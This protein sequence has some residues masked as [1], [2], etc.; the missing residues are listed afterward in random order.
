MTPTL[1]AQIG[2]LLV[3]SVPVL[4]TLIFVV[5]SALPVGSIGTYSLAPNF[6]LAMCLYWT[7]RRPDLFPPIS[8]F[9]LG[10]TADLL[11]SGALG[12]WSMAF[13]SAYAFLL[14]QRVLFVGRVALPAMVGVAIG[15]AI[16]LGIVWMLTGW[17][18]GVMVP[19][20][21]LVVHGLMT[22]LVFPLCAWA[23]GR[24]EQYLPAPD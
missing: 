10:L 17:M 22:V 16:G 13:L 1:A 2:R 19:L 9:I 6:G 24:V 15:V 23:G 14:W 5:L 7:L 4:V 20:G 3:L 11:G 8:P 21:P 12:L 18:M